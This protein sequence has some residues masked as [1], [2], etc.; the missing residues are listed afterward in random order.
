MSRRWVVP[1]LLAVAAVASVLTAAPA[2][3]RAPADDP[4]WVKVSMV[5]VTSVR[6][7]VLGWTPARFKAARVAEAVPVKKV[8]HPEFPT[9]KPHEIGKVK[10]K[11]PKVTGVPKT[12]GRVFFTRG[13]RDYTCAATSVSGAEQSLVMT[14]GHCVYDVVG[15]AAVKSLVFV[16]GYRRGEAPYGV[17]AGKTGYVWNHFTQHGDF[18]FDVAF[19]TVHDGL[20]RD[21]DAWEDAGTLGEVVGGQGFTW[22]QKDAQVFAAFGYGTRQTPGYCAG[23]SKTTAPQRRYGVNNQIG[24][25][26]KLS[27]Q[28]IGGPFILKYDAAK[29]MGYVNGVVSLVVTADGTRYLS[30]PYFAYW[31]YVLYANAGGKIV[32][33]S[34]SPSAVSSPAVSGSPATGGSRAHR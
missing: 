1:P 25:P 27:D 17:Y 28:A 23:P 14:A 16:P 5:N 34:T 18:D 19:V 3:A 21:G 33:Q 29:K 11:P 15:R 26:C 31:V 30:S 8:R 10:G 2:S 12:V 22:S 7:T 20:K 9:G 24:I 4:T 32:E 6:K 13:G